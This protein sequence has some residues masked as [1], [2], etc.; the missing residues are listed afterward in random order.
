MIPSRSACDPAGRSVS[1]N[2]FLRRDLPSPTIS[3]TTLGARIL[4]RARFQRS[5]ARRSPVPPIV[6]TR[7]R[8]SHARRRSSGRGATDNFRFFVRTSAVFARGRRVRRSGRSF[9]F[10]VIGG[11]RE[12]CEYLR[13]GRFESSWRASRLYLIRLVEKRADSSLGSSVYA[14]GSSEQSGPLDVSFYAI[15]KWK[16]SVPASSPLASLGG[17]LSDS[18]SY[19]PR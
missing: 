12:A 11:T 4:A 9:F 10:S 2:A 19:P 8:S 17:R 16:S 5:P 3:R 13:G 7:Q 18:S 15:V 1:S 14:D 6:S